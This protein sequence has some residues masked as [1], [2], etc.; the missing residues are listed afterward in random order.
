MRDNSFDKAVKNLP[1]EV[2]CI[3]SSSGQWD[4]PVAHC[5]FGVPEHKSFGW[6]PLKE[7]PKQIKGL[8]F[9]LVKSL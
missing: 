2:R 8:N 7:L 5:F 1:L 6:T 9:S 3:Q 4:L